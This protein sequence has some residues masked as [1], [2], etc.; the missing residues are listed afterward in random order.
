MPMV[1]RMACNQQG[2]SVLIG[3]Q[4][5]VFFFVGHD[6]FVNPSSDPDDFFFFYFFFYL[7]FFFY[8]ILLAFY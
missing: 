1:V 5:W 8:K 4:H 3:K 7:F 6:C 2:Y